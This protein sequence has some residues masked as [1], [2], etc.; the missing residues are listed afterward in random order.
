M[1][2]WERVSSVAKRLRVSRQAV[3]KQ[4][5]AGRLTAWV[6]GPRLTLV[7]TKDVDAWREE[8]R[9]GAQS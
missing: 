2:G 1:S 5:G 6:A 3:H 7:L 8:R 4:I 9:L